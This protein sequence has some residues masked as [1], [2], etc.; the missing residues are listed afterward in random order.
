MAILFSPLHAKFRSSPQRSHQR[1]SIQQAK[2]EMVLREDP[3]HI[4]PTA[5]NGH[6]RLHFIG[7]AHAI[8]ASPQ[9]SWN[10]PTRNTRDA[11]METL[12][13]LEPSHT[14]RSMNV[15]TRTT[16]CILGPLRGHGASTCQP[17]AGQQPLRHRLSTIHMPFLI[18]G[19][20]SKATSW[21]ASL[22]NKY[23]IILSLFLIR[24]TS[25][26]SDNGRFECTG[27]NIPPPSPQT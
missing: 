20:F 1:R 27:R 8:T 12:N 17:D 3:F 13:K 2:R 11:H 15:R 21:L 7:A 22:I 26:Q 4:T 24:F 18:T 25:R 19:G 5:T 10:Q 16:A 14:R 6:P 9:E 23:I